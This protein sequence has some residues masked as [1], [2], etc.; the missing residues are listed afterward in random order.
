MLEPKIFLKRDK[1]ITPNGAEGLKVYGTMDMPVPN[2][3]QIE[4]G[5][6]VILG[7]T[8]ENV[9]QQIM[10]FHKQTDVYAEQMVE[11]VL[12]SV[13]LKDSEK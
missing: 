11:R 8:A 10:I 7:F 12:N 9:I 2:T 13:E 1:F 3:D 4:K 6:Y 5:K